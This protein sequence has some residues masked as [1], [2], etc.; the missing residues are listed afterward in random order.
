MKVI[1]FLAKY[2]LNPDFIDDS[3]KFDKA[4]LEF[5]V[6]GEEPPTESWWPQEVQLVDVSIQ[7]K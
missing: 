1:N 3:K 2:G 6:R 4:W 5:L 7:V